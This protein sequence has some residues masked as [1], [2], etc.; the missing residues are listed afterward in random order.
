VGR[1]FLINDLSDDLPL[2]RKSALDILT[3][4]LGERGIQNSA[5]A[6]DI[7]LRPPYAFIPIHGHSTALP[8][9]LLKTVEKAP[10]SSANSVV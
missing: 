8:S 9:P 10:A 2:F 6:F 5:I 7:C 1:R 3:F 4:D